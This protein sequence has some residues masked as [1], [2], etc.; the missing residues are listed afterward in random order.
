MQF[1]LGLQM[2]SRPS[3]FS[4]KKSYDETKWPFEFFFFCELQIGLLLSLTHSM[5]SS[6]FNLA[7]FSLCQYNILKYSNHNYATVETLDI[8]FFFLLLLLCSVYRLSS[9]I[10]LFP[11]A[12]QSWCSIASPF[13]YHL[14]KKWTSLIKMSSNLEGVSDRVVK[15]GRFIL[16][17][18]I[19]VESRAAGKSVTAWEPSR[20]Q[21]DK[22]LM[23]SVYGGGEVRIFKSLYHQMGTMWV[24]MEPINVW[25]SLIIR[26]KSSSDSISLR[27][28]KLFMSKAYRQ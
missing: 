8:A 16:A 25:V 20:S 19:A 26:Q 10:H 5:S 24:S 12:L 11:T 22:Q 9:H 15:S 23:V 1:L 6:A 18:S 17:T 2:L 7:S 14:K 13:L 4:F 21:P 3:F 28:K 27:E